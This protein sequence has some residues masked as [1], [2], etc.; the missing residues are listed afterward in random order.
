MRVTET[1]FF[2]V[3][4]SIL[5]AILVASLLAATAFARDAAA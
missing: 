4:A 3:W 5:A 1:N 2:K